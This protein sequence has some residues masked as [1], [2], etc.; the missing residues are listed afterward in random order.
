MPRQPNLVVIMTDTQGADCVGHQNPI[1]AQRATPCIDRL[2]K[3]G[4][5]FGKAYTTCPVCTPARAGLFTGIYAQR[6][7][8]WTN[9]MPLGQGVR[10][11]G[12]WMRELGYRTAYVG[13]W[14]LDGHDYFGTGLCPDGWDPLYWYDGRNY[15]DDLTP[16]N[17]EAWRKGEVS[18]RDC[19]DSDTWAWRCNR[20]AESF[21]KSCQN[22]ERPYL[23]VVSY[24]EP[25]HPYMAPRSDYEAIGGLSLTNVADDL[26]GKPSH[27]TRWRGDV[28]GNGSELYRHDA[29]FACNHFVD[30]MIGELVDMIDGMTKGETV[31]VYTSDHGDF[32]GSHGGLYGKGPSAYEEIARIPLVVRGGCM[33][34][35]VNSVTPVSHVD[36]LPT[37]LELA[38]IDK[39]PEALDGSSLLPII[40]GSDQGNREVVVEF[41]RYEM[42][43]DGF[44]DWSPMRA[45]VGKEYKLTLHERHGDEMYNTLSDKHELVNLIN[46]EGAVSV[47]NAMHDRL[48]KWMDDRRDPLRGGSWRNRSWRKLGEVPMRSWTRPLLDDG[49]RPSYLDYDTAMVT[50]GV[51]RE[52]A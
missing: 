14:H 37:L 17:R 33:P 46:Q 28:R 7:G 24:D 12:H 32:H 5:S 39:F 19:L 11:M 45:I 10:H 2:A 25:H 22:E 51:S 50:R 30:R 1:L 8:A 26:V 18:G 20:K 4:V 43:H 3:E 48:L 44:M 34:A 16:S 42:A 27:Y 13:K 41:H 23:L 21:L 38:G 40:H 15:I 47:R 9:L 6:S 31:I 49:V 36:V 35:A 29:Y 52:F